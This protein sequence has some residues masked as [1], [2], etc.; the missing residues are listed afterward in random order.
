[1]SEE[2]GKIREEFGK[3]GI[4]PAHFET[5]Y[6]KLEQGTVPPKGTVPDEQYDMIIRYLNFV[7]VLTPDLKIVPENLKVFGA[8]LKLEKILEREKHTPIRMPLSR[9]GVAPCREHSR[10][11]GNVMP[12]LDD[13]D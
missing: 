6:R 5:F 8:Q 7:Q 10:G 2:Y 4:E 12:C 11:I 1:M 13:D 9:G 3:L